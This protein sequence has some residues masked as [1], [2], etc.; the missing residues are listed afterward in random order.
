MQTTAELSR[1]ESHESNS[2]GDVNPYICE[3]NLQKIEACETVQDTP[4]WARKDSN[5]RPMDYESTA[6]TN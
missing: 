3:S 4:K 1:T 5:L 2:E 6:L